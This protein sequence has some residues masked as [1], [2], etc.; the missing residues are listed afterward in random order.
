[1]APRFFGCHSL[2]SVSRENTNILIIERKVLYF[3]QLSGKE[4]RTMEELQHHIKLKKGD[5]GRY[6]LLPGDPGR[7]EKIAQWFDNPQKVAQN[8]EFTTY[9]GTLLGEK[10][11]VTSTGIG[12]ASAAIAVEELIAVGADTFLRVGTSGAMQPE[13]KHGHLALISAAI[14]DDGLTKE[15][16]P[17]EFPAVANLDVLNALR[18]A[19]EKLNNPYHVGI[20]HSKDSFYGQM[21]PERMPVGRYLQD[22]WETWVKAGAICAEMETATVL[23]LG[24]IYR[25]RSGSITLIQTSDELFLDGVDLMDRLIGNAVEAIKLLIERDR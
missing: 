3:L 15:Y 23:T 19:A 20:S 22:R 5:V 10:V 25:K 7:C 1:M 16:V 6:V 11:A 14:R 12:N 8:R 9:T 4:M 13:T 2:F 24:S 17:P 18:D 21:E